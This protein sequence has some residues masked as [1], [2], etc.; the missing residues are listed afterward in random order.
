M[1]SNRIGRGE[2]G[3]FVAKSLY[4]VPTM[5]E[6]EQLVAPV[7]WWVKADGI[8]EERGIFPGKNI[9][10]SSTIQ[11]TVVKLFPCLQSPRSEPPFN[12]T[13][14]FPRLANSPRAY[15][16]FACFLNVMQK[17]KTAKHHKN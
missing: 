10:T 1:Y 14:S 5:Q 15:S 9:C 7:C 12:P 16:L 13:N 4:C 2:A 17:M 11:L 8:A 6:S 3:G